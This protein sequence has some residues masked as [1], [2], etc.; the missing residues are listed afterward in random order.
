MEIYAKDIIPLLEKGDLSDYVFKDDDGNIANDTLMIASKE[1]PNIVYKCCFF[2]G[3]L[4]NF[5]DETGR[6][7]PAVE[8]A[9]LMEY[10]TNGILTNPT[11][12]GTERAARISEG[13]SRKEYWVDGS[14]VR[15]SER[16]YDENNNPVW[17]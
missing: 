3:K 13:F 8:S 1:D 11:I 12:Y 7:F 5:I 9:G 10:R 4:S 2:D 6:P 17:S 16:S 14:L 15:V